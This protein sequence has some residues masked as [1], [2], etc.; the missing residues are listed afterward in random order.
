M[1]NVHNMSLTAA[2]DVLFSLYF[3]VGF[4]FMYFRFRPSK[5]KSIGNVLPNRRNAAMRSLFF[6]SFIM[7]IAYWRT[8]SVCV[9]RG[10]A[11]HRKKIRKI[12]FGN[13]RRCK[14]GPHYLMAQDVSLRQY[15]GAAQEYLSLMVWQISFT[16]WRQQYAAF[17]LFGRTMPNHFALL[18]RK[19]KYVKSKTTAKLKGK[20]TSIAAVRV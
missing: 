6:S 4:Y 13:Y 19:R 14:F 3:A 7:R 15:S 5:A 17:C 8:E 9:I 11:A 16:L 2:I 18:G 12:K 10:C 20:R 1:P